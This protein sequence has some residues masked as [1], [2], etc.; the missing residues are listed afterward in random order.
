MKIKLV[1]FNPKV[2]DLKGNTEKI[3]SLYNEYKEIY[4]LVVFPELAICGYPPQDLINNKEF[5]K[6]E[7]EC[8]IKISKITD[9]N[10]GIIIGHLTYDE[11]CR[12]HFKPSIFN[13]ASLL[14]HG[15]I[16]QTYHKQC[17]PTYD[18]FDESRWFVPGQKKR[19]F[20]FKGKKIGPLICEDLWNDKGDNTYKF[21]GSQKEFLIEQKPDYII[22]I[23]ASPTGF[24]KYKKRQDLCKQLS[25]ESGSIVYYVNQYG[26]NDD[27]IFD[28]D[29]FVCYPP[30]NGLDGTVQNLTKSNTLQTDDKSEFHL[31]ALTLGIKE[32]LDK[33]GFKKVV[34]GLSGGID[35]ALVAFLAVEAIGAENVTCITMPSSFSSEGSVSD[36]QSLADKLGIELL[37]I[38]I[39]KMHYEFRHSF[40][41]WNKKTSNTWGIMDENIQARIRGNILMAFSNDTGAMVLSTS[42]KSESAVGYSTIYGDM[43]G[44]LA[45]ISDLYKTEVFSL[46]RLIDEKYLNGALKTIINKPPSAELRDNQK[47]QDSLPE[48]P[49]LDQILKHYIEPGEMNLLECSIHNTMMRKQEN[50]ELTKKIRSMVDR[51][52][53]KR[54]QAPPTLR[55]H[56]N[57]WGCGRRWPIAQGF[58]HQ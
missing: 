23:N 1:P 24:Q 53:Y 33:T 42:N 32:Y 48:Y 22:S 19:I 47:D 29:A 8:L 7:L 41:T 31:N 44:G 38:P 36:S 14:T 9:T 11:I 25:R 56:R 55:V 2:G 50:Y 35:S 13:S 37:E 57:A 34:I 20:I 4:D 26:A 28:G 40:R 30:S 46:C 6:K 51:A 58:T 18:V 17:L 10:H 21:I 45:P 54:R 12:H 15:T 52:E 49:L 27:L 16:L 5:T 39:N 3:I 43:A